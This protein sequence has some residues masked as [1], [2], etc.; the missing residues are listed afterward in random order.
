MKNNGCFAAM[1]AAFTIAGSCVGY[2][3]HASPET[4]TVVTFVIAVIGGLSSALCG[5]TD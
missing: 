3:F 2:G 4:V 1:T 5:H